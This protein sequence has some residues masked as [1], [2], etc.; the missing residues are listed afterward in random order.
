LH[1]KELISCL[2]TALAA[3]RQLKDKGMEGVHLGN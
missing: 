1:P 3:A 2:E